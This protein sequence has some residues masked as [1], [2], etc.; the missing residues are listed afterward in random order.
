MAL[1]ARAAE[2]GGAV[3][4]RACEP[5][6]VRAIRAAV[7]LPIIALTK[8]AYPDG[9]VLITPD[10]HDAERLLAAGADL[11]AVDATHRPRPSGIGNGTK[12]VSILRTA[13]PSVPIVADVSSFEEGKDAEESGASFV[14]T[15]LSGYVPGG[16]PSRVPDWL[17]LRRLAAVLQVPIILEGRVASPSQARRGLRLGASCVV[18]GTAITRPRILVESYV[19]SMAAE[20]PAFD[21]FTK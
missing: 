14:A 15:T 8:S 11:I 4:I 20:D 5:E 19:K 17:L 10:I 1:F 12:V 7:R 16:F 13:F 18:V 21:A 2:M 3:A 9:S 6:N